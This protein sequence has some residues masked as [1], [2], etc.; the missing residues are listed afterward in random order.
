MNR[1]PHSKAAGH[2][3][4]QAAKGWEARARAAEERLGERE[5]I[6]KPSDLAAGV[7]A[8]GLFLVLI[9]LWGM[10]PS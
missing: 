3:A 6:I 10:M 1:R 8:L 2:Y 7:F 4:L 5:I 9:A